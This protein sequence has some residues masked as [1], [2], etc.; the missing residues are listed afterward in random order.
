MRRGRSTSFDGRFLS[1]AATLATAALVA[2]GGDA[3]A[4]TPGV[5][6]DTITVGVIAS[7]S[8]AVAVIGVPM[9]N[10]IQTYFDARNAEGGIGGRYTVR[11]LVEDHTYANPSTSAQKYQKVKGDVAMF[12]TVVGTDHINMLIP[13]LA[14]DSVMVV[15]ASFDAEWVREPN[16]LPWSPPYQIWA[17]NGLSYFRSLPGNSAKVLCAMT[18][19]TGYGEAGLEGVRHGAEQE[20]YALAAT[21]TFKQDDQDF[22]APITQLRNAKC[23]AVMLASLPGTTG[24]VLGAA[25]Q[26]GFAPQ[27]LLLSPGWLGAFVD[28]PLRDYLVQHAWVLADAPEWGDTTVAGMRALLAARERFRPDQKPDLYFA[29][30]WTAAIATERLLAKAVELG[31]LSRA[32]IMRASEVMGQVSFDGIASDY[33]YGPASERVPPRTTSIFRVDPSNPIGLKTVQSR[34]LSPA[35]ERFVFAKKTR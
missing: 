15:P 35:A 10:A 34:F 11:V 33:M 4:P 1:T 7:Q 18:L 3:A 23:D 16:I 8:D 20:G 5:S 6:G 12:A 32:G 9:A 22:V 26:A 21:A 27:W 13:L 25:A 14:E 19:A 29:A 31:D 28:S 17:M 30:G 24:R 2:C